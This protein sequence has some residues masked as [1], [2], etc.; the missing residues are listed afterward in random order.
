MCGDRSLGQIEL[1]VD[2]YL[3]IRNTRHRFVILPGHS[4]AEGE[5]LIEDMGR[6]HIVEKEVL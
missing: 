1:A 5:K 2:D 6:F 3:R 4:I